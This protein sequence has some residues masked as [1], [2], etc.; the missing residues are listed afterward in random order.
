MRGTVGLDICQRLSLRADEPAAFR[1]PSLLKIVSTKN[2]QGVAR[3]P[4]FLG[5]KPEILAEQT[6]II[7]HAD[8]N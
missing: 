7:L 3:R 1:Q 5:E 4:F 8:F 2:D 6:L